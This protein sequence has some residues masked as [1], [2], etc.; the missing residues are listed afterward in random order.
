ML[1]DGTAFAVSFSIRRNVRRQGRPSSD[2]IPV[3]VGQH[4]GDTFRIFH[5]GII[6]GNFRQG[7]ESFCEVRGEIIEGSH[8][9]DEL[10]ERG[11]LTPCL[12]KEGGGAPDENAAVPE[13]IS[14]G[15]VFASFVEFRLFHKAPQSVNETALR[16]LRERLCGFQISVAGCRK[17]RRNA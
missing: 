16:A 9:F 1:H 5:D 7:G 15:N 2:I 17:R 14:S 4:S 10:G 13:E 6:H 11:Q 12:V 8:G 3:E